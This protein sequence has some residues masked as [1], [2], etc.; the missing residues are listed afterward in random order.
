[1]AKSPEPLILEAGPSDAVGA[2]LDLLVPPLKGRLAQTGKT[3]VA[4]FPMGLPREHRH[5]PHMDTLSGGSKRQTALPGSNQHEDSRKGE[6]AHPRAHWR[7]RR[8][9]GYTERGLTSPCRRRASDTNWHGGPYQRGRAR[10][11]TLPGAAN[12]CDWPR[13]SPPPE[14]EHDR[15]CAQGPPSDDHEQHQGC[16]A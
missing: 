8:K 13:R 2:P 14:A 16:G 5:M 6:R 11:L 3:G 4:L 9:S 15:P 10:G 12:T 7:Y 1:M